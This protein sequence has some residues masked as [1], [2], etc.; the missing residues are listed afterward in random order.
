MT[1]RTIYPFPRRSKGLQLGEWIGRRG[2]E[3]TLGENARG[4]K[5]GVL[6]ADTLNLDT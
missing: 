6:N 2:G 5:I 3:G 1:R 4:L